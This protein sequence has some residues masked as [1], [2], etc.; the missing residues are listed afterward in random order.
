MRLKKEVEYV[1]RDAIGRV[2]MVSP[3]KSDL[4]RYLNETYPFHDRNIIGDGR[5]EYRGNVLPHEF[6][7]KRRIR[8]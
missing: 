3:R 1:L 6:T 8:S 7:I 5:R 2:V 4:H